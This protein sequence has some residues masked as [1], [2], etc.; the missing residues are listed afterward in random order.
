MSDLFETVTE[1]EFKKA[2]EP[3]E[4]KTTTGGGRKQK[5]IDYSDRTLTGWFKLTTRMDFCTVP[6]HDAHQ[7][8]LNPEQKEYRQKYP[9]RMV[10]EKDG[11][12]VCRDC[13]VAN[14]DELDTSAKMEE[15]GQNEG[16]NDGSD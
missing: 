12:L 9:T 16:G 14:I 13:F 2:T 5:T 3:K 15:E 4:R 10:I 6:G 1:D 11:T 8:E 7:M